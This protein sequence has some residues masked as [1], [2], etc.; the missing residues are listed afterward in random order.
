[1]IGYLIFRYRLWRLERSSKQISKRYNAQ[2]RAAAARG[3]TSEEKE[4]IMNCE[5][6]E[7]HFNYEDVMV[8]HTRRLAHMAQ[9]LMI[10][11]GGRWDPQ[12]KDDWE[13]GQ[14]VHQYLN[15]KGIK[16]VR[17]AIRTEQKARW[18]MFLMWAPVI[19][20]LTGLVGAA[21]GLIAI[22]SRT[23]NH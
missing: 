22:L 20:G 13:E 6:T 7:L 16:K 4:G 11:V 10:E 9:A 12:T 18:E 15:Q 19:T 1:M 3:A 8:L 2:R 23:S 17:D 5:M 14:S 21:T